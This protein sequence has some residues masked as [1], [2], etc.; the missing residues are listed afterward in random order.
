MWLALREIP[1]CPGTRFAPPFLEN[2]L[3][4]GI[5]YLGFRLRPDG[6]KIE[7]WSWLINKIEKRINCWHHRLLSKAGRLLL[8]KSV[9]E[10]TPVY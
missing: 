10:A 1:G 9:L 7:H 5:K 3:L 6:Y 2:N 4:E 8:I